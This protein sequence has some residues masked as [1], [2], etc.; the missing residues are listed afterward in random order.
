[1]ADKHAQVLIMLQAFA[2]ELRHADPD[3]VT[4]VLK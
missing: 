3:L 2:K 1:M 4:S